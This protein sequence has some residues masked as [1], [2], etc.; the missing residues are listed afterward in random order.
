MFIQGIAAGFLLVCCLDAPATAAM[1]RIEN[2]AST[3]NN[4]AGK[5]YNPATQTN[6][7][8]EN[9][10]NPVSRIDN[11][12]P[13]SQPTR[14]VPVPAVTRAAPE[15]APAKGLEDQPRPLPAK[16]YH[17]KTVKAYIDAAKKSFLRDDHVEFLSITEDALRRI[18][19]GTL[20]ASKE[21]KQLLI[22]YRAFGYGLLGSAAH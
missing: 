18:A 10:Y 22:K 13:L 4:P 17:L 19:A 2:P 14:A 21:S 15:A 7:P 3:I 11:P 20:K 5:M 8:A 6:N 9:I 12:N 16:S 1:Y